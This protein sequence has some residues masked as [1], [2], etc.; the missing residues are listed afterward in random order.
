VRGAA[1]R[2][3]VGRRAL[4]DAPYVAEKPEP[5]SWSRGVRHTPLLAVN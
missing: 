3:K 4:Y 2:L 1:T 5:V